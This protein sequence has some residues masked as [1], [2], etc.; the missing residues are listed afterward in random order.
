MNLVVVAQCQDQQVYE[1]DLRLLRP[2]Q[3]LNDNIISFFIESIA[4]DTSVVFLSPSISSFISHQLDPE[5][6]DYADEC[7]NFFQ[8]AM[9]QI[10]NPTK[11]EI[12]LVIPINSSFS[13]S[14]AAFMQPG[15]GTHW[16]LLHLKVSVSSTT[17]T[18]HHVHYDSSPS[19]F[20]L[21]TATNLLS[22]LSS[23]LKAAY[24]HKSI[25][26][27]I[28]LSPLPPFTS[29][30]PMKQTDGYSCGWFTIFFARAV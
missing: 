29:S 13:D 30:G 24:K 22:T 25:T 23:C 26:S 16:S 2:G 17:T 1:H 20:N 11:S 21:S 6:E 28:S 10:L 5:D 19:N 8:G 7:M 9:P 15:S 4:L 12:N 3:W 27:S 14:H 18:I